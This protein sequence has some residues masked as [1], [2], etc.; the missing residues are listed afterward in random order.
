MSGLS[1]ELNRSGIAISH[2]DSSQIYPPHKKSAEESITKIFHDTF[3]E[4]AKKQFPFR[5]RFDCDGAS[6]QAGSQKISLKK[7]SELKSVKRTLEYYQHTGKVPKLALHKSE[8]FARNVESQKS[9]KAV[10]DASLPGSNGNILAGMRLAD[11][12]LALTRNIMYAF[13]TFGPSNSLA[14]HLGY[15]AGIFWTF[16]AFRE[17]DDGVTEYERSV[18]IGDQEGVRRATSRLLSGSLVGAG[19]L[20]YLAAKINDSFAFANVS[21]LLLGVSNLFFGAGSLLAA[22][23]SFLGALRCTRFNQRLD[24]YLDHPTFTQKEKMKGAVEFLK[25]CISV[26]AEEKE[27]VAAQIQKEHPDWSRE[28]KEQLL[29]QRLAD[30]TEVK[31]KYMKRRASNRGLRLILEKSDEILRKFSDPKLEQEAIQEAI[32]LVKAVQKDSKIKMSLYILGLIAALLSFVAMTISL[33]MSGGILPFVLYS[34]SGALYLA[35]TLYS[36]G[37]MVLK[38]DDDIRPIELNPMQSLGRIDCKLNTG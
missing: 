18:Q 9:V 10:G 32:D 30:L 8:E 4:T 34:I 1:V 11:D 36:I 19:S 38:R 12:T 33:V 28:L 24:Q 29:S 17:F 37:V 27:E 5:V 26:T 22:G 7:S 15:Y 35:M 25:A 23:I 3:G 20:S 13:P 6:L 2:L 21:S 16:F 31:V 14:D